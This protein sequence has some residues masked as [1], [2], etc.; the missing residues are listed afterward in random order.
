MSPVAR[1]FANVAAELLEE[2]AGGITSWRSLAARLAEI[3]GQS[4]ETWKTNLRRYRLG[5]SSPSE[6]AIALVAQAFGVR[7]QQ[8]PPARRRDRLGEL[9]TK[10]GDVV[11]IQK[12]QEVLIRGLAERVQVLE[13][14]HEPGADEAT[15]LRDTE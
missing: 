15:G 6:K 14:L 5:E 10:V 1:S 7:R 2:G 12:T 3:S 11:E 8:F 9:A 4:T 13:V